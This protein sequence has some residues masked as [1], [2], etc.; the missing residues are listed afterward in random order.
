[1]NSALGMKHELIFPCAEINLNKDNGS[2]S[3]Q[4]TAAF[5]NQSLDKHACLCYEHV[6][7]IMELKAKFIRNEY[8]VMWNRRNFPG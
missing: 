5:W 2:I 3:V 6:S 4:C 1:M 7:F 8:E